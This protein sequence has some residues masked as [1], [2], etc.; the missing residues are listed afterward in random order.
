[1]KSQ[2]PLVLMLE[3]VPAL[4]YDNEKHEL[5]CF[6]IT[7]FHKPGFKI[8]VYNGKQPF[9]LDHILKLYTFTFNRRMQD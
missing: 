7:L 8:H 3:L 2:H 1:M 9:M 4:K 5:E 6:N